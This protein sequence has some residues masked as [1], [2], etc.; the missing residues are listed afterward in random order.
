MRIP[1]GAAVLGVAIGSA[2]AQT[3]TVMFLLVNIGP[4]YYARTWTLYAIDQYPLWLVA[5][6]HLVEALVAG[7]LP[8]VLI[9]PAMRRWPTLQRVLACV[10]VLLVGVALACVPFAALGVYVSR[11]DLILTVLGAWMLAVGAAAVAASA[12]RLRAAREEA[13]LAAA[14]ADD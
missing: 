11:R 12:L 5:V 13:A 6:V 10:A 14:F 4:H 3:A 2:L 8:A 1:P 7:L 9:V